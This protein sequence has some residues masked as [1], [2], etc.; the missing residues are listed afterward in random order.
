[1]Y[2]RSTQK[3]YQ[4]RARY[5]AKNIAKNEYISKDHIQFPISDPISDSVICFQKYSALDPKTQNFHVLFH[6]INVDDNP[7]PK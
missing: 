2:F 4:D 1:L 5:I 6:S 7:N 3:F